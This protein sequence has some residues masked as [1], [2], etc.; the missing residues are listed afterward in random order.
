MTMRLFK[1]ISILFLFIS[2]TFTAQ[3]IRMDNVTLD[4]EVLGEGRKI[5][6]YLPDAYDRTSIEFP[7]VLS[8]DGA[9]HEVYLPGVRNFLS[10]NGSI[11][12]FIPVSV[13]NTDRTRDFTPIIDP[14]REGTGGGVKFYEFLSEELLP[15]VK[16]NYRT[17]DFTIVLG[18]SLTGMYSMY[19]VHNYPEQFHAA[20]AASPYIQYNEDWLARN[21]DATDDKLLTS[22]RMIY[23]SIG[24]TETDYFPHLDKIREIYKNA[25]EKLNWDFIKFDGYNH[26]LT[27]LL[28]YYNGLEFIFRDWKLPA[29]F[30]DDP[31]REIKSHYTNLSEKYN[32]RIL[33]G[34]AELNVLGYTFMQAEE[35]AKAESVFKYNTELY[36]ESGNVWDSFGEFYENRG[37]TAKAKANYEI[38][39]E[40]GK[41]LKDPNLAIYERNLKR[42]SKD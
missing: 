22:N 4:S 25:G 31:V 26:G 6:I 35:F 11:R 29:N 14:T 8:F 37:E 30:G 40:K 9:N 36:S 41:L 1:Q 24:G 2:V 39:V 10:R 32:S 18:H 13:Y 21:I 3:D 20:V 27:P 7:V 38:A 28:T 34:E 23:F 17:V 15:Y 33:P 42:V 19:L 16:E 5:S 12:D